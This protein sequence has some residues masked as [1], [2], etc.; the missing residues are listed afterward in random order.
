M[1]DIRVNEIEEQRTQDKQKPL[2]RHRELFLIL[3]NSNA[4]IK[5]ITGCDKN[6]NMTF[7]VNLKEAGL[8]PTVLSKY[9]KEVFSNYVSDFL[10]E[11]LIR[12]NMSMFAPFMSSMN[13]ESCLKAIGN[14]I[15]KRFGMQI[16]SNNMIF[17]FHITFLQKILTEDFRSI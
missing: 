8:T 10:G 2:S 1:G 12:E 16:D 3:I 15:H 7:S 13:M 17:S 5:E 6:G 4:K 11:L 9:D 14:S